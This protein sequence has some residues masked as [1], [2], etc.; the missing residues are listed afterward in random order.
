MRDT[1]EEKVLARKHTRT[2][3]SGS[4]SEWPLTAER[5]QVPRPLSD[6]APPPSGGPASYLTLSSSALFKAASRCRTFMMASCSSSVRKL[7]SIILKSVHKTGRK[8]H[9]F[10]FPKLNKSL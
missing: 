2:R 1:K 6:R 7:K 9:S 8:K 4:K 5:N 10:K 3:K